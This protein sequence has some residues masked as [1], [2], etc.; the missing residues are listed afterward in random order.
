MVVE[1]H[2]LQKQGNKNLEIIMH[3]NSSRLISK[4]IFLNI[5]LIREFL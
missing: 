1:V 4:G 5:F 2:V 3:K